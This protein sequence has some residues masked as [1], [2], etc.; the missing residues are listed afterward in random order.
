[1]RFTPTKIDGVWIVETQ[2][3]EDERGWFARCWC[4]EEFAAHGLNPRMAQ[5]SISFNHRR[6]TLRGMHWQGAPHAEAK[7]VRCTRGAFFDVALDVRRAS[8]TFK[9]WVGVELSMGHGAG[10]YIPEGCAHG[11]Q[12]LEDNTE[13]HYAIA[14]FFH[15]ESARGARWNDPQFRIEWPL[16]DFAWLSPRDAA[17]PDFVY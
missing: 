15:P 7:L 1:M 3:L 11:F 13:V 4:A 14:E 17:Y 2:R 5:C 12:T 10:L 9:Q 16:P 6:G 8:P